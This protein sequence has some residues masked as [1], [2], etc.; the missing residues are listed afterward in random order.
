MG[1]PNELSGK[2]LKALEITHAYAMYKVRFAG[3]MGDDLA[4]WPNDLLRF[5][6][7]K[8]RRKASKKAP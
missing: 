2:E 6:K 7:T 5:I 4:N 3:D 1:K 8:Q